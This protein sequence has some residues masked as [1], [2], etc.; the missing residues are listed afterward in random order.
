[1]SAHT[2]GGARNSFV[3]Q[4]KIELDS[5]HRLC[6]GGAMAEQW[7]VVGRE[8]GICMNAKLSLFLFGTN[9]I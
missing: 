2:G 3:Y 5:T 6:A 8:V 9:S 1:V 4:R 7:R